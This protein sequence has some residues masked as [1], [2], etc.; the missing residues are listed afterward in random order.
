MNGPASRARTA[1][2]SIFWGLFLSP[3]LAVPASAQQPEAEPLARYFPAEGLAIL[4][5]HQGLDA[6]P[7]AWKGTAAYKMLN[8]TSLGA[9]L[10][11]IATQVADRALRAVPGAPITGKEAVGLLIH[12]ARKGFAVGLVV[13]TEP[14]QPRA[15][16]VVIRDAAR[17]EVFKQ[18]I[19]RIP[20]LNAPAARRVQRPGGRTVWVS[21]TPPVRWWYE[22]DDFIV[23]LTP[24]MVAD[25]V[26]DVL[27]GK[28]PS[29][30]KHEVYVRL[31]KPVPGQVPVGVFFLDLA[32][33]VNRSVM[34]PLGPR[35]A[36]LGLDGINRVESRWGIQDKGLVIAVAVQAPRPRRGVLALFDQPTM[37]P[38]T[39]VAAP[40]GVTGFA[41]LS[42]DP[43]RFGDDVMAM[44]QHN[45][46]DTAASLARL[47]ARFR[48]RTGLSLRDDLLG[49]LGPRMAVLAPGGGGGSLFGMWFHPPEVGVVAEIKDAR[50]FAA[51]LDRLMT[52]ANRELKSAGALVPPQRG[53]PSRPGTEYAEFRRLKPPEVGY[54]LTI[55]PSVLPTPAGL[56]PTILVDLERG[57]IA[58][59]TTLPTA[60]R[61]LPALVKDRA[62]V[63]P[64][65]RGDTVLF[66]Q[67]DPS[68]SLPELL[69]NLPSMV[70]FIGLAATQ[71]QPGA[72]GPVGPPFRLQIDPDAIPDVEALR[73]HL[74]P[75][76]LT[77]AVDNDTI[78]L[79]SYQAFPL[80]APQLNVGA[81]APVLIALLLPAVQAARE[82]ARRAQCTNNLKQIG[83]AMLNYE[84]ANGGLPAAAIVDKQRKPLLSWR[85]TILPYLEQKSLYDKFKLDEPWD[86]PHNR[87]LLKEMPAVYGCPSRNLA[88][89]PGLT[90]YRVFSGPGAILDPTR[91]TPLAQVTDGTTNTLMVVESTE[92]IPW[93][94]PDDLPFGNGRF[95]PQNPLRG[96]GSRH[97]GGFNALFGDASVRFIKLSINP[98][99]FQALITKSGGEIIAPGG[100]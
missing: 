57:K 35:A 90:A 97:P 68:G 79:S 72:R 87:A 16:V 92:A 53:L 80:P 36:E 9:M 77:V 21:Q 48:D 45:D 60:R 34:P 4:F 100:P 41:L 63:K 71:P 84:S 86:S 89:E 55:P 78:R 2:W 98:Q 99:T 46:P 22:K 62:V 42:V 1:G 83:L 31:S 15:V 64:S 50:R 30:L 95:L 6:H 47:V 69:A 88:G 54:I 40:P 67:S 66:V 39:S 44:M 85:V 18:L 65:E 26:A 11:D 23:S 49:Q 24:N 38:G 81:E 8:E 29:A 20:P 61:I 56:R 70:Q 74:F 13:N 28:T 3:I 33:M 7:D 58:L 96:A 59:A 91:K 75:S 12:L 19:G 51:T 14:P 17:N 73:P 27:D 5:E 10:E 76:R 52:A 93:T 32:M 43:I 82:A 25:P 37:G 94:K